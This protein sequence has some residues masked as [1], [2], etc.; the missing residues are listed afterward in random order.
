MVLRSNSCG[1]K[2]QGNIVSSIF[3]LLLLWRSLEIFIFLLL[4]EVLP[5]FWYPHHCHILIAFKWDLSTPYTWTLD[6]DFGME[7]VISSACIVYHHHVSP[8]IMPTALVF[9]ANGQH[10]LPTKI[11]YKYQGQCNRSLFL[12]HI[13]VHS[14]CSIS[15]QWLCHF[16]ESSSGTLLSAFRRGGRE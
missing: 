8:Q 14:R 3:S 6:R 15:L 4:F 9:S 5:Q 13:I 11:I 1:E 2:G 12:A 16:L 10:M 7:K